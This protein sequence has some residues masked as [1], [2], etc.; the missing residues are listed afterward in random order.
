MEERKLKDYILHRDGN[1]ESTQVGEP[2]AEDQ[3]HGGVGGGQIRSA[4]GSGRK[5]SE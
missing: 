2:G 1:L 3:G 4:Q 5:K